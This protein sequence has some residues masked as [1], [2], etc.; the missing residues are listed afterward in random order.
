MRQAALVAAVL[1]GIAVAHAFYLSL[2]AFGMCSASPGGPTTC[3][4]EPSPP[5]LVITLLMAAAGVGIV[6][7]RPAVAWAG[8]LPALGLALLFGLSVGGALLVHVGVTVLAVLVWH[9]VE[10]PGRRL[11]AAPPPA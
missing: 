11:E 10:R 4:T 6:L 9:L 3:E 2:V 1:V 5:A 8:A 7:A